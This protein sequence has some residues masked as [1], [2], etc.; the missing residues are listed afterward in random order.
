[1]NIWAKIIE[2]IRSYWTPYEV[3]Q[4]RGYDAKA[5]EASQNPEVTLRDWQNENLEEMGDYLKALQ[6]NERER[7]LL[8]RF[9][10]FPPKK[11]DLLERLAH[12][13]SALGAEEKEARQGHQ[14]ARAYLDRVGD[15][16]YEKDMPRILRII[17]ENELNFQK[18]KM[19]L[20]RL[21]GEKSALEYEFKRS[22]LGIRIT[23]FILY[24]MIG[25]AIIGTVVLFLLARSYNIFVP[26]VSLI[27]ALGF[28]GIWAVVFRRYFLA[29][30]KKNAGAQARVVKLLNK[31][32]IKYVTHRNL[33]D[34][35]YKKF[36]INSSEALELRYELSLNEKNRRHRLTELQKQYRLLAL[37]IVREMDLMLAEQEEDL[38]DLF[39]QSSD[40][41]A[42][43]SGRQ[44]LAKRLNQEKNDLEGRWRKIEHDKNVLQKLKQIQAI[45]SE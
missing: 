3:S 13:Y 39:L 23:D 22:Q 38:I 17:E 18:V 24:A 35:E 16:P 11:R 40:Y 1:M 12:Q 20:D 33:L 43:P 30:L 10:K 27:L 25:L 41:Y 21:E 26:A 6:K 5:L 29:A 36:K 8:E 37:D 19:D 15:I 45:T 4:I 2:K 14:D 42:S 31:I 32:K 7:L 9:S 44:S 34:Y 28:F